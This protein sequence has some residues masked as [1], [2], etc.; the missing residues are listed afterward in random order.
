ML[1]DVSLHKAERKALRTVSLLAFL[2]PTCHET[3]LPIVRIY[4]LP[5]W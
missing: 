4:F 5:L 1:V 2:D 3:F